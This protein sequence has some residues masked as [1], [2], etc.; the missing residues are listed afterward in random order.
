MSDPSR[1]CLPPAAPTIDAPA[2]LSEA[3]TD[4]PAPE[5]AATEPRPRVV[6]PLAVGEVVPGYE[7]LGE[8]GRGGMGVVYR[9]RDRRLNRVVALKMVLAGAHADAGQLARFQ[10]EAEAVA[11]LRH[12]NVV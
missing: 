6:A 1:P 8:L 7:L 4:G 11:A 2:R 12:P 10:A 5:A 9:A 3:P